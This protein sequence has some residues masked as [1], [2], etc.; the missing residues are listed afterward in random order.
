MK[1]IYYYTEQSVDV[2]TVKIKSDLL[3][4][5]EEV[6]DIGKDNALGHEGLIEANFSEDFVKQNYGAIPLVSRWTDYGDDIQVEVKEHNHKTNE[7]NRFKEES[8]E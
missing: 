1:Y 3:L 4:S 2:R 8:N 5:K 6:N 7:S